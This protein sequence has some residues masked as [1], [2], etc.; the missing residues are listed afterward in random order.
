MGGGDI[1]PAGEE[2]E[3]G[4]GVDDDG[5]GDRGHIDPVAFELIVG[6]NR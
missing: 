2:F 6:A 3:V 4:A 5:S 1:A